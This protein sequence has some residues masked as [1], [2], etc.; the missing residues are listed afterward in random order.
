VAVN[1]L[2]ADA[3]GVGL[4]FGGAQWGIWD[5]NGQPLLTVDSVADVEYAHDYQISDYP[6]E[7]GAFE[8]YNKVQMPFQA[9]IGFFVGQT[10]H[11]FLNAIEAKV[12]SLDLVTV[13][14]PE[15]QYP[16]ANL[17]HVGYRRDAHNGVTLVRVEVW[18]EEVRIV[19]GIAPSN[20]QSTNAMTP[21]QS[22]QLQPVLTSQLAPPATAA[23][24]GPGSGTVGGSF[25][26]D[27]GGTPSGLSPDLRNVSGTSGLPDY[28]PAGIPNSTGGGASAQETNL[29]D[30][31]VGVSGGLP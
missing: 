1:L 12:A 6:Q 10:R 4:A 25:A 31:A 9:K 22:G 18:C 20:S 3:P 16:S 24:D 8:S 30:V 2:T 11:D 29:G 17:T 28:L 27:G 23:T 5:Q 21:T 15:I 26:I 13:V 7:Q 19:A 14:T